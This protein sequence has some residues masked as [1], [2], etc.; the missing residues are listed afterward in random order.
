VSKTRQARLGEA[1]GAETT[2]GD[3][4]IDNLDSS[5]MEE[6]SRPDTACQ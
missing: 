3:E 5:I 2:I 1:S 4:A 6:L